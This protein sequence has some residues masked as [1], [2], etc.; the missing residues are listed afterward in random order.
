M[1]IKDGYLLREIAGTYI[2]VPVGNRVIEFNGLINLSESGALLWKE[3]SGGAQEQELV[4]AI[5]REY[6][7]DEETAAV[8]VKEYVNS[9]LE[10]GLLEQ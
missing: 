6:D 2:V 8:D 5:R 1:R 7:I 4:K 10:R 9:L 3:L